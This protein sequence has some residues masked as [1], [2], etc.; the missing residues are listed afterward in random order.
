MK[1]TTARI[2]E[3]IKEEVKAM[4]EAGGPAEWEKELAMANNVKALDGSP[5]LAP[6]GQLDDEQIEAYLEDLLNT[7]DLTD[8]QRNRLETIQHHILG[9]HTQAID[10]MPPLKTTRNAPF[11]DR[12]EFGNRTLNKEGLA[13]IIHE[14][15]VKAIKEGVEDMRARNKKRKKRKDKETAKD[16]VDVRLPHKEGVVDMGGD[17]PEM[18]DDTDTAAALDRLSAQLRQGQ[19]PKKIENDLANILA[20]LQAEMEGPDPAGYKGFRHG[21]Y[22]DEPM[23]EGGQVINKDGEMI[24]TD[25]D[26]DASDKARMGA[27]RN[28]YEKVLEKIANMIKSGK[29]QL[30]YDEALKMLS[31]S[32]EKGRERANAIEPEDSLE[33]GE[34]LEEGGAERQKREAAQKEKIE[35]LMRDQGL[36]RSEA[37]KF[38]GRSYSQTR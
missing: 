38:A 19:D 26:G 14:E 11:A 23:E 10:D 32:S 12:D 36:S 27:R 17:D 28:D 21:G 16:S 29:P 9:G 35:K 5:Q 33:G 30:A 25:T 15:T 22:D 4:A 24:F 18:G 34:E 1:I 37:T 20:Q 31:A 2:K 3:I 6:P 7:L 8:D 13:R